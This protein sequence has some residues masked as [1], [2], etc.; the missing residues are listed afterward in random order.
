MKTK[1]KNN[2]NGTIREARRHTILKRTRILDRYSERVSMLIDDA[3]PNNKLNKNKKLFNINLVPYTIHYHLLFL[4]QFV[5]LLQLPDEWHSDWTNISDTARREVRR[6]TPRREG[7]A[8][9]VDL[10][11]ERGKKDTCLQ[12]CTY[13]WLSHGY[14]YNGPIC[15]LN[16]HLASRRDLHPVSRALHHTIDTIHVASCISS[17]LFFFSKLQCEHTAGLIMRRPTTTTSFA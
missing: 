10:F 5:T 1:D 17:P 3:L 13:C 9:D 6:Q 14:Y 16:C 12:S 4:L 8:N 7:R 2:A 15:H 11:F